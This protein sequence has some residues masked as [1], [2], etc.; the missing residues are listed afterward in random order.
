MQPIPRPFRK[1]I[2]V[3]VNERETGKAACGGRGSYEIFRSLK[4]TMRDRGL[5][6]EIRVTRTR[7]LG[8]CEL[9][10]NVAVYP[11]GTWYSGMRPE[12]IPDLL[13][14]HVDAED[15]PGPIRG[16]RVCLAVEDLEKAQAFF[17]EILGAK[18]RPLETVPDQGFRYAPF[19]VG[20]YSMELLSPTARDG[21]IQRFLERRGEGVHHLTFRVDDLDE[22]IRRLEEKGVRIA[23]RLD[24]PPEVTFE[25]C[26]WRE[27]FLHPRDAFGILI[28]FA[29]VTRVTP[30]APDPKEGETS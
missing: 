28:H 23:A 4:Q 15:A 22:T 5:N 12:D 14:R 17:Q 21:V 2:L 9:G 16:E 26:H 30:E 25:G 10:P 8:I 24:Y 1:L 3:C 20:G 29:E 18:F 27:A 6:K 11:E 13:A 7:C 19:E